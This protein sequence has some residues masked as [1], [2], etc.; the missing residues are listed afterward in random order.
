VTALGDG[1]IT[2][3]N[4]R[5]AKTFAVPAGFP[6]HGIGVGDRVEAQGERRHG[7][8]TLTRLHREDR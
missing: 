1:S 5:R 3:T 4:A 6:L 2:V 8:L 7:V